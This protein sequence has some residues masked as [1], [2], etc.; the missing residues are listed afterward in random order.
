MSAKIWVRP[1]REP[2]RYSSCSLTPALARLR[3]ELRSRVANPNQAV[4]LTNCDREP[5]HLI[6]S[7]Q[8]F[9]LL[10]AVSSET[11][12]ITRASETSVEWLGAAPR[13]L[14]GRP[15][16]DVLSEEAIHAA[17][18]CVG[19]RSTVETSVKKYRSASNASATG[20]SPTSSVA[21]VS[22]GS[23]AAFCSPSRRWSW[24]DSRPENKSRNKPV[25]FSLFNGLKLPLAHENKT[26]THARIAP[27]PPL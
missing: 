4:Y 12:A 10:L 25:I 9:G 8:P 18:R 22:G 5:I 3:R 23:T 13:D 15:L 27:A 7:I 26:C 16:H 20:R 11:W 21:P 1:Q 19:S 17:K 2:V 6:G 24:S 14:I